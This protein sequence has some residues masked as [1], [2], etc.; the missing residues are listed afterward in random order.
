MYDVV[1]QPV[2][3]RRYVLKLL[4]AAGGGLFMLS[5]A[6]KVLAEWPAEMFGADNSDEL[7]DRLTKGEQIHESPAITLKVPAQVENPAIV[8]VSI[9]CGLDNVESISLLLASN[10]H[11][12]V[13]TF[14]YGPGVVP[15][16]STRV[17][18]EKAGDVIALVQ[19]SDRY[20]LSRAKVAIKAFAC[21]FDKDAAE[22]AEK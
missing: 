8:P 21:E 22:T 1:A 7:L 15:V 2:A 5:R 6:G 4:L 16:L 11:P 3:S 9:E 18:L 14:R 17:K 20:Y 10:R 12:M 13:G 19:T